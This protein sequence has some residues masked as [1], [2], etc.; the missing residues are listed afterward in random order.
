MN[1][2]VAAYCAAAFFVGAAYVVMLEASTRFAGNVGRALAEW[3]AGPAS[4]G[5]AVGE[6]DS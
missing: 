5:A 6:K 1:R 4:S 2:R 3:Q